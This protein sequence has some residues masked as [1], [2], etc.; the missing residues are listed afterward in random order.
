MLSS[1]W[2]SYTYLFFILKRVI[3]LKA[4]YLY[5]KMISP[6]VN[7]VWLATLTHKDKQRDRHIQD[8]LES[9]Y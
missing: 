5:I 1:S 8:F 9:L 3:L 7:E 6:T 2:N 4:L